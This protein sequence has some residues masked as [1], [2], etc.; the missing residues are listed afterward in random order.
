MISEFIQNHPALVITMYF[1]LS[2]V[3]YFILEYKKKPWDNDDDFFGFNVL[4]ALF[5]LIL[6]PIAIFIMPFLLASKL[7]KILRETKQKKNQ[8]NGT[9]IMGKKNKGW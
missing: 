5:W 7:A 8:I 4:V 2:L 3:I 6:L 9:N 1:I